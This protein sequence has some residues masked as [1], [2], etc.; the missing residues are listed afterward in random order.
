MFYLE[1]KRV[2]RRVTWEFCSAIVINRFLLDVT[3]SHF[4]YE[5][6]R[7]IRKWTDDL[8]WPLDTRG[9]NQIGIFTSRIL[10]L[11]HIPWILHAC[12]FGV[13]KTKANTHSYTLNRHIYWKNALETTPT[14][15]TYLFIMHREEER[16]RTREKD[17]KRTGRNL[18]WWLL[19]PDRCALLSISLARFLSLS[20]SSFRMR[21]R[22]RLE[23]YQMKFNL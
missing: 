23:H 20:L 3:K 17:S 9:N 22:D 16:K 6:S 15:E 21:A 5:F 7:W 2:C 14:R 18:R 19:H 12:H 8:K 13:G 10:S 4:R 1:G 11:S